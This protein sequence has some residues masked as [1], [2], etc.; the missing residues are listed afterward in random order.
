ME[1]LVIDRMEGHKDKAP[2]P[3]DRGTCRHADPEFMSLALD[4]STR[5]VAER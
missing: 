4:I 3:D 5:A 1:G 2:G